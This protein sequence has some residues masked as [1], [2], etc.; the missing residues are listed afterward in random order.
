ME[1][2]TRRRA[3]TMLAALPGLLSGA[4]A[5][6]A[7]LPLYHWTGSALGAEASI[8]LAA[9]SRPEAEAIMASARAEIDRLENLLSLYRA[10]GALVRL[11]EAGKL[12]PAPTEMLDLLRLCRQMHDATDGMFDPTIQPLWQAAARN[13]NGGSAGTPDTLRPVG[14]D[15][16]VLGA[17][18]VRFKRPGMAL[19]LNGIAQG[20]ITDRIADLFRAHGLTD[21]LVNLGE[22]RAL[23]RHPD[24]RPWKLGIGDD[25]GGAWD[26]ELPLEN[27]SIATSAPYGTTL[28]A[29]GTVPQM[30]DPKTLRPAARWRRAS[31]R[32]PLA[33]V[34]DAFSTAF[35]IMEETQVRTT[36]A[37]WPA[38]GALL[39]GNDGKMARLGH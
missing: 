7:T 13:T 3:L 32:G 33:A 29:A 2:V 26:I 27:A 17:H 9:A 31:V 1:T 24:G 8:T 11:N 18:G 6:A 21:I 4:G 22:Y 23:G 14:F 20:Y 34:A 36:L 16:V 12:D 25:A 19:T 37:A 28:D 10:Q 35:S 15:L 30:I 5:A 39:V 38:Y